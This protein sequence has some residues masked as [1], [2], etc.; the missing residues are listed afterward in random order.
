MDYVAPPN[1]EIAKNH[2]NMKMIFNNLWNRRRNNVWLFVE[3]VLITL[4]TWVMADN[5]AVSVADRSLPVGYDS[6]RLVIAGVASLPP[7]APG[8]RGEY[9]SVAANA[10]AVAAIMQQ[11]RAL[12]GVER[13]AN[14]GDASLIGGQSSTTTA[15][16]TGNAAVDTLVK[17]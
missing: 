10:E 4:L 15:M 13:A 11:L 6:D 9:D 14:M 7:S 17:A 5:V 1:C 3:L 12:D 2:V 8:Y 16:G